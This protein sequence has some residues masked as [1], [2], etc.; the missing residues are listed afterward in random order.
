MTSVSWTRSSRRL[1]SSSAD[2]ALILWDVLTGEQTQRL[3]LGGEIIHAALHPR[4]RSLCVACVGTGP[5]CQAFLISLHPAAEQ[6][7][8]LLPGSIAEAQAAEG[9]GGGEGGGGEGGESSSSKKAAS[10]S[11]ACFSADGASVMVGTSRG[12]VHFLSTASREELF[13]VQLPGASSIKSLN[14][15]RDG[16]CFLANSADRVIRAYSLER[17]ASGDKKVQPRELQDV[18]NR[19]QWAHASFSP[20]AADSEHV[21]GTANSATDHHVYI[22]DMHGHLIKILGQGE[23]IK[24]GALWF[25]CHPTRPILAACARSGAI[26][27][28]TKRYSENWSA[29]APDFK[30]LEEN[31][32]Y[33][34]KEDE[35]DIKAHADM[36]NEDEKRDEDEAIDIVSVQQ[37]DLDHVP[38]AED[39]DAELLFLPVIPQVESASASQAGAQGGGS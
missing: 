28:W 22:W 34:E 32:E 11:Y 12:A 26:Y 9:G 1:L 30:E 36:L 29:F 33:E 7:I 25:A 13:S 18:V 3:D 19:M 10:V 6:R 24:D 38:D 16:K 14:I 35:F 5:A 17:V 21:V 37:T 15:S 20:G 31:E 8:P 4:K 2:G 23:K 27:I 39:D